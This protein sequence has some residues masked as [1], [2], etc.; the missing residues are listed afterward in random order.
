[1]PESIQGVRTQFVSLDTDFGYDALG[2]VGRLGAHRMEVLETGVRRTDRIPG[3]AEDGGA[4][5]R[6]AAGPDYAV[7]LARSRADFVEGWKISARRRAEFWDTC[8][9]MPGWILPIPNAG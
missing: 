6:Q 1:M 7:Q 3:A 9:A 8:A 5:V 2:G 4:M